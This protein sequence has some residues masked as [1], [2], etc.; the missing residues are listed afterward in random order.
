M[1]CFLSRYEE[2]ENRER[3]QLR[4]EKELRRTRKRRSRQIRNSVREINVERRRGWEA[5]REQKELDA[6][7]AYSIRFP[8][9]TSNHVNSWGFESQR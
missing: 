5:H 6:A 1:G 7:I 9:Q 3:A 8:A 2:R 4:K